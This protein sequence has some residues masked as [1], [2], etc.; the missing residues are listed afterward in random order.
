MLEGRKRV[1]RQDHW[2][3][4]MAAP[5]WLT[6]FFRMPR[7]EICQR[8]QSRRLQVRLISQ[9]DGP[10]RQGCSPS[11]PARGALNGAEHAPAGIWIH[12]AVRHGK[13]QAVQFGGES[14]IR[15]RA[16]NRNLLCR[17]TQPHR[18]QMSEHR[19]CGPGQQHLR[20]PHARRT[21]GRQD[22]GAQRKSVA[23]KH[24]VMMPRGRF[25][26]SMRGPLPGFPG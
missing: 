17:Q 2:M 25:C 26:A 18:D 15:G 11:G 23:R 4:R 14:R 16:D 9:Y 22:D 8:G 21:A 7:C 1:H 19:C 5:G 12:D 6:D 20:S 10:M 13:Q 3:P 24:E